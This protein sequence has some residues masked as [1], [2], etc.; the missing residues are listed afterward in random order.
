M[1]KCCYSYYYVLKYLQNVYDVY[2][3]TLRTEGGPGC[4]SFSE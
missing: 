4:G 2:G 1:A 3:M